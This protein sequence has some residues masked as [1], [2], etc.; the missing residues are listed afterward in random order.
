MLDAR[1]RHRSLALLLSLAAAALATTVAQPAAAKFGAYDP[2]NGLILTIALDADPTG[3]TATS[4]AAVEAEGIGFVGSTV[5][6]DVVVDEISDLD[7]NGGTSC[8]QGEEPGC[9][10]SGL[11]LE[12]VYDPQRVR[13]VGIDPNQLLCA[14]GCPNR[15]SGT[16]KLPDDDGVFWVDE[17]D[18]ESEPETGE[19]VLVRIVLECLS[20][21]ETPLA[22]DH[23]QTG[24]PQIFDTAG[25][26]YA[27]SEVVGASLLCM[28]GTGVPAGQ[29]VT[30]DLSG[31]PQDEDDTGVRLL[32]LGNTPGQ[33]GAQWIPGDPRL[34]GDTVQPGFALIDG[35]LLAHSDV[36]AGEL[37]ARYRIEYDGRAVRRAGIR[38]GSLRLMR[39][40]AASGR[41]ARAVRA[42][43]GRAIEPRYLRGRAAD[44]ELGHHGFTSEGRYVWAVLDVNSRYAVGGP[45]AA[46]VPGLVPLG[47]LALGAALLG[48]TGWELR[49]RR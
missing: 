18:A 38:A 40:N 9:G 20:E 17:G 21:G 41:W 35:T 2:I 1:C 46:S 32:N 49:R 45:L 25:G 19:G 44:F 13:V 4:V 23:P 7:G 33:V 14:N 39:R 36:S 28:E 29:E 22:L 26:P 5:A 16:E 10:L 47:L 8:V 3:N 30:L 37:R 42:L 12:L 34:P 6:V 15:V 27:V 43:R 31:N 11:Q 48:A 24:I